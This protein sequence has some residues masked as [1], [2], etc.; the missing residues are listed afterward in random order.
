MVS[1]RKK[2]LALLDRRKR[3]ETDHASSNN[4]A[5]RAEI[6]AM[7]TSLLGYF[8]CET[9]DDLNKLYP[10][11][12][13]MEAAAQRQRY[14]AS[15][16]SAAP[17]S[18]QAYDQLRR[19][20]RDEDFLEF[21][22]VSKSVFTNI[23][24]SVLSEH[25]VFKNHS[26]NGQ[27]SI[28]KQLAITLW[29]LGHYGKDTGIGEAT[30]IF[31][32]SEGSIMKCTQRCMEALKD[33]SYDVISWPTLGEKRTIKAR[34]KDL[35]TATP[36]VP[37]SSSMLRDGPTR[38]VSDAVGIISSMHVLL[39]SKP[40]LT[41]P[42]EYIVPL[43]LTAQA[44]VA[45]LSIQDYGRKVKRN[46]KPKTTSKS[47][48]MAES[49]I[50]TA[51]VEPESSVNGGERG[52]KRPRLPRACKKRATEDETLQEH[53]EVKSPKR[54]GRQSQS[55]LP[56]GERPTEEHDEP[57]EAEQME[58]D[59]PT[60]EQLTEEHLAE[61]LPTE[62]EHP[63]PVLPDDTTTA[64]LLE[65]EN[66]TP[67]TEDASHASKPKVVRQRPATF[68]KTAYLK[69][70]YGYNIIM[71]CDSTTRIRFCDVTR[72]ASWSDQQVLQSSML[73][74]DRSA[75]FEENEY[76]VA[77]SRF[78]PGPNI[79]PMYSESELMSETQSQCQNTGKS[80]GKNTTAA[81]TRPVVHREQDSV[82][83][84]LDSRRAFNDSLCNINKR[85]I[86]CQR[87]LKARFPS[88]LGMRVQL[89]DDAASRENAR[90][91]IVA[92]MTIHN[93]VLGDNSCYNMEWEQKLDEMENAILRLQEQQAR[94]M[95]KLEHHPPKKVRMERLTA[96]LPM[97]MPQLMKSPSEGG[98]PPDHHYYGYDME[99]VESH[100]ETHGCNTN[101]GQVHESS[102]SRVFGEASE[103]TA[104]GIRGCM[105]VDMTEVDN[106]SPGSSTEPMHQHPQPQE[107]TSLLEQ[108]Q[109]RHDGMRRRDELCA[110]MRESSNGHSLSMLLN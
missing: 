27:E 70:D 26:N 91:W 1:E 24:T 106:G 73:Y 62:E 22:R 104:D 101:E 59:Q 89:K 102:S 71:A 44:S 82:T 66:T 86:D 93:L 54:A 60:E 68:V 45:V 105:E 75:F 19:Q 76:L 13:D 49:A 110:S 29:R 9:I 57:T 92:C 40:L 28:E 25:R 85:S 96:Q 94:L 16:K 87:A 8:K 23:V 103:S 12:S 15:R 30:K 74:T 51:S 36:S 33:I 80:A 95:W 84:D 35:A 7:N 52:D 41:D 72:P 21:V 55:K 34:I 32:V 97:E 63:I 20:G 17:K 18:G 31:G 90:N 2:L 43:P 78:P 108:L 14:F 58:E 81:R 107:D 98:P 67:L 83:K 100:E 47:E 109:L 50:S 5:I 64:D 39:V 53:Q 79:M 37:Q 77:D 56:A 38:G 69:R 3:L 6:E 11:T 4:P 65:D 99:R 88:L 42:N 48:Q 61:R 10:T 46:R